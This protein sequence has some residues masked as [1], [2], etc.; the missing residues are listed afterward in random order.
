[1][2]SKNAESEMI[3]EWEI[4]T[5]NPVE[6]SSYT[7]VKPQ[8]TYRFVMNRDSTFF[9]S[10]DCNSLSGRYIVSGDSIRFDC[11]TSTEM[12]CEDERVEMTMKLSLPDVRTFVLSPNAV[13]S[14]KNSSG[15][16]II[17][18]AKKVL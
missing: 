8:N 3:G 5:Y 11:L 6:Y 12:A 2:N 13:V 15:H 9:C 14:L 7:L 10:T 1:M 4:Y 18:L 17:Q 16:T